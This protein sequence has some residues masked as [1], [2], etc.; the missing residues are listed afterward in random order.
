MMCIILS[1]TCV[2]LFTLT[3]QEWY[4]ITVSIILL[5]ITMLNIIHHLISIAPVKIFAHVLNS[6]LRKTVIVC[7]VKSVTG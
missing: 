2:Y 6:E 7:L 4:F 5:C 3:I 1:Q